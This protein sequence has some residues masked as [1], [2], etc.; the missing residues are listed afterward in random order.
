MLTITNKFEKVGVAKQAT[1]VNKSEA[2]ERLDRSCMLCTM[3]HSRL[4]CEACPIFAV[5]QHRWK[6]SPDKDYA[7]G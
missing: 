6:G 7:L 4:Q 3:H 2:D 5:H 1:A